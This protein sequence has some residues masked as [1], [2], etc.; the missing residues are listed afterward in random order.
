M[1]D[2]TL[3]NF[4]ETIEGA[5]SMEYPTSN[6][7]MFLCRFTYGS[8][9][10]DHNDNTRGWLNGS[11]DILELSPITAKPYTHEQAIARAAM[12][13]QGGWGQVEIEI[14]PMGAEIASWIAGAQEWLDGMQEYE[15]D[16]ESP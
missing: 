5:L 7:P 16:S 12:Y 4:I 8:N 9:K 14:V 1:F 10:R 11:P 6:E 2:H 13:G 3:K 15:E